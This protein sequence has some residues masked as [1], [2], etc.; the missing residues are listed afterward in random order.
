MS[1]RLDKMFT[2]LCRAVF[3]TGRQA[4]WEVGRNKSGSEKDLFSSAGLA[5]AAVHSYEGI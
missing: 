1:V 5:L 2:E 4:V 3:S